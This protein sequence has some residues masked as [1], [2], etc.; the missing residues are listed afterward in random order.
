MN[1]CL[2]I[3]LP[4]AQQLPMISASYDERMSGTAKLEAAAGHVWS[5][6]GLIFG[7]VFAS[8]SF[9]AH[10]TVIIA[11]DTDR[12]TEAVEPLL[13][14]PAVSAGLVEAMTQPLDELLATD[15]IVQRIVDWAGLDLEVPDFLD[16]AVTA[17]VEPLVERTLTQ[18]R[19]GVGAIIASEPFARSWRQ[20]VAD[21]HQEMSQLLVGPAQPGEELGLSLRPFL[22]DIQDGLVDRGFDFVAGI[23]LPNASIT[24]LQP[25][26]VSGLRDM[27][28]LALVVNPWGAGLALVLIALGIGLAPQRSRAWLA[29]GGGIAG[30]MAA[31]LAVL[32]MVRNAWIPLQYPSQRTVLQPLADALFAYPITQA[33]LIAGVA[34]VVGGAGWLVERRA[35]R[36]KIMS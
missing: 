1:I 12:V 25:D 19:S 9:I 6:M 14:N 11:T 18:V 13:D 16:S 31:V 35:T 7:I 22:V 5:A 26:T 30:A 34:V 3:H 36:Q 4:A 27:V 24:L 23:P 10:H 2:L 33:F 17:L 21:T 28:Q 32:F 29:A 20:I 8:V 15:Q